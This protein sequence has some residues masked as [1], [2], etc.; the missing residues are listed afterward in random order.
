LVKTVT[1]KREADEQQKIVAARNVKINEEEITCKKL[2][3]VVEA[4]LKEAMLALEA[5]MKVVNEPIFVSLGMVNCV[6]ILC[7]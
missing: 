6:Q 2:A 5:A 7:R 4:D 1:Q 3:D